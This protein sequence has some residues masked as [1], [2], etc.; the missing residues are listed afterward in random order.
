MKQALIKYIAILAFLLNG[1][2][3]YAQ[4]TNVLRLVF[5]DQTN[6]NITTTLHNKMPKKIFVLATT[7]K[8]YGKRFKLPEN[9]KDPIVMKRIL[10]DE[11]HPYYHSYIFRD[12][13][14]NSL[15]NHKQKEQLYTSSQNTKPRSLKNKEAN[16][17]LIKSYKAVKIG[18][19]FSLTDVIYTTDKLF[20]MMDIRVFQKTDKNQTLDDIAYGRIFLIYQKNKNGKW[21]RIRKLEHL[22]L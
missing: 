17:T 19:F 5:N 4:D 21:V 12:S 16:F 20:A 18:F 13:S 10:Q 14:L 1:I 2:N 8:W 6:F 22:I 11:H 3:L 15:F 7:D 9:L